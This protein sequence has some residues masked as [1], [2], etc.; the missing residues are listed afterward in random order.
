MATLRV[1]PTGD[2]TETIMVGPLAAGEQPYP[3]PDS[4]PS[5]PLEEPPI[6]TPQEEPP[7]TPFDDGGRTIDA[8]M[9]LL[10]ANPFT[11]DAFIA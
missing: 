4:P 5:A 11:G 1:K 9:A 2:L 7:S 8:G 10:T 6:D 3:E